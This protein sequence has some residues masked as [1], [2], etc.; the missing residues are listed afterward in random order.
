MRARTLYHFDDDD[1]RILHPDNSVLATFFQTAHNAAKDA[2]NKRLAQ[3][4]G[5]YRANEF[6]LMDLSYVQ[7][8]IER[9]LKRLTDVANGQCPFPEIEGRQTPVAEHW[10]NG[11][12]ATARWYDEWL[13]SALL[14]VRDIKEEMA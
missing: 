2:D 6:S 8:D 11:V 5:R 1:D 13:R 10:R 4:W 12:L 3:A 9:E 14:A 7:G